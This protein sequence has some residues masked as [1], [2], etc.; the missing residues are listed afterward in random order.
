MSRFVQVG[1]SFHAESRIFL[2]QPLSLGSS[3]HDAFVLF[4]IDVDWFFSGTWIWFH[5]L[6]QKIKNSGNALSKMR[7]EKKFES[8]LVILFGFV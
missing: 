3:L 7:K 4:G 6:F 1:F 5:G 2:F 8:S